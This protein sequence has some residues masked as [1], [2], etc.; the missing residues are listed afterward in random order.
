MRLTVKE[1]KKATAIIATRYQKARKKD[2]G[3]ILDEFTELTGY[4]RRY[5]SHVLKAQG[6]KVWVN[7]TTVLKGDVRKHSHRR[8]DPIYDNE[9]LEA[10]KKVWAIMDYICGK[11]LAPVLKEIILRLE[12]C[13]EI[14]LSDTVR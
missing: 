5:A 1:R 12:R 14:R 9:V 3:M 6:R 4:G 13:G 7:E 11:R 8:K 2:K 10:L